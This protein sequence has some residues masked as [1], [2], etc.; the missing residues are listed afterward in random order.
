MEKPL[1][2]LLMTTPLSLLVFSLF[3]DTHCNR[4]KTAILWLVRSM[5]LLVLLISLTAGS[6]VLSSGQVLSFSLWHF[7]ALH[8]NPG[9]YLDGL[10]ALMM[11]LVAFISFIVIRYALRYLDGDPRQGRFMK[12]LA[13]TTGSVLLLIL[14]NNL[15]LFLFA[16]IATSLSLHQLL[17]HYGERRQGLLAAKKKFI[18]SR[19][20]DLVLIAALILTYRTFGSWD[21]QTV[22]ALA[23]DLQSSGQ[24]TGVLHLISLLYVLGAMTKSAQFPVHSWLPETME[25]PTPVS[26]LM[27]A[28]II[29]AG[30]FLVVRL[31]PLILL[32]RPALIFLALMGGFTAL[33]GG[34]VMLTQTSIKQKLA[35]STI[36]QMGFMMLQCGL[37]AFTAATLH[38]IAHSLYKAHA[39][40]SSGSTLDVK[41]SVQVTPHK[42]WR[43]SPLLLF[44]ALPL[45][46]GFTFLSA[47]FWGLS[48]THEAGGPVLFLILSLALSTL[49]LKSLHSGSPRLWLTGTLGALALGH[50]YFGT[51]RLFAHFLY[52]ALPHAAALPELESL[53]Y[54]PIVLGFIAVMLLE[55]L[56]LSRRPGPWL[57]KAYVLVHN[58]F[59]ADIFLHKLTLHLWPDGVHLLSK[60]SPLPN[61]EKV[62]QN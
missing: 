19:I 30:G 3:S 15:L 11:I 17:T 56:Y 57:Q 48:L 21:Y 27:H 44:L 12:W 13:I 23:S 32:S 20:G 42:S 45:A 5:S 62:C 22:F 7:S 51:Y 49:L 4:N 24:S 6:W 60:P 18:V 59:Y 29:N 35:Y 10:S 54:L 9:I 47:H 50:I 41:A 33:F 61:P 34:V 2:E 39:F 8:F 26:A 43:S 31:S 25:T 37:G 38:I 1:A 28:G 14:A 16:W 58:A 52:S 46:S 55:Y 53:L 40:L 36:S